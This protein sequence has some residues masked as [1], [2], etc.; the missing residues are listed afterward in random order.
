LIHNGKRDH[1]KHPTAKPGAGGARIERGR[2][3]LGNRRKP[4]RRRLA[5]TALCALAAL[6]LQNGCSAEKMRP[7]LRPPETF[8]RSGR[9]AAPDEWW[10]AFDDPGLNRLMEIALSD[11]LDIK[12]AWDRLDQASAYYKVAGASLWPDLSLNL[13]ATR[14]KEMGGRDTID[15]PY[16]SGIAGR[17]A[18]ETSGADDVFYS[19]SL[20]AS[21]ELDLWGRIRSSRKAARADVEA[22]REELMTAA[23][24][25]SGEVANTWCR[26][27]HKRAE[28]KILEEQKRVNEDYLELLELRFRKGMTSA[29]EVLQQEREL[30]AVGGEI[31]LAQMQVLLLEQQLDILL[32]R[33]PTEPVPA[34]TDGLPDM[35]PLPET[36][37]PAALLA[38]RP[39]VTAAQKRLEAANYRVSR[40]VAERLPTVSF[41]VSAQDTEEE[42][43]SL[44]DNWIL[45]LAANLA[46]P[47]FDAGRRKAEVERARAE[48]SERLHELEKTMLVALGEVEDALAREQKQ[49]KFARKLREQVE[50]SRKALALSRRRYLNG[51]TDYLP[52]LVNLQALQSL[53][54]RELE[55][56]KDLL[57]YRINLYR[58]LAGGWE[59]KRENP[60][61]DDNEEE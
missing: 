4:K 26:L 42:I 21:Y 41:T 54:R 55:A 32:G 2:P 10:K 7:R 9:A 12:T 25:I 38:R 44:F 22:G 3:G 57:M 39:D 5:A 46:A 1:E 29:S 24:T 31:S 15:Y 6:A 43:R 11:N 36:G 20:T 16:T 59:L 27:V 35:P 58:A 45:N 34:E 18:R 61:D 48:A 23:I 49:E 13:G 33:P 53:E 50:I 52:V 28:L 60:K 30:L 14:R 47:V 19:A 40:A 56:R 37:I 51:A 17:S 8:S